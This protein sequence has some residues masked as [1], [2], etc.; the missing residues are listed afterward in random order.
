[1]NFFVE[2]GKFMFYFTRER[3]GYKQAIMMH[4]RMLSEREKKL[5]Y[6]PLEEAFFSD[7]AQ[8]QQLRIASTMRDLGEISGIIHFIHVERREF[9]AVRAESRFSWI[10]MLSA[11]RRW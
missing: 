9:E 1:M 6:D 10:M 4:I 8:E 7:F 2:Y 3:I 11:C 5:F